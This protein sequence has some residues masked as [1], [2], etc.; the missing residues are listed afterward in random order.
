MKNRFLAAVVVLVLLIA[1]CGKKS[2]GKD[3]LKV[4]GTITNSPVKT[5]YLE[6]IPMTTMQPVVVDSS[7]IDKSGKY[8]LRAPKAEASVYNIR[9]EQ[10]SYPLAGVINDVNAITVDATF[11]KEN[12][13]FA[14]TYE[15][16]GSPVSQ[17]MKD[18]MSEVNT[19]LQAIFTNSKLIDSLQKVGG[20]DSVI[21]PFKSKSSQLGTEIKDLLKST[22][23]K[24]TN[25]ALTM[26]ALGYYQSTASNPGFGLEPLTKDEVRDIVTTTADKFPSHK[27]IASIKTALQGLV[28]APAPEISL[29]D[30]NGKEVKLSAYKG[31]YV[32]V[33]FWASWC[34][35]CRQ[36]NPNVVAAYK[37]FREKNFDILGVSLDRPGEKDKWL[38]AIK[39]DNLTWTHV[40]DLQYWNSVVVPLYKIE[41]IPFNVLVDPAGNIIAENLRGDALEKKLSEVLK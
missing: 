28:G 17:Q 33:D 2:S 39:D 21:A 19:K 7:V 40:S 25:P 27:G 4:S 36:E 15:I 22:I 18:F 32:L 12:K 35:P 41:G 37:K 38:K 23:E 30:V 11:N 20:G 14:E 29:P 26:I 8:T 5:I 24:S 9:L 34:G 6:E 10:S 3:G 16:K 13:Q 31:K 1:S